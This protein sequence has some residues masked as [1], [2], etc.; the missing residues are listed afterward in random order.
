MVSI[1]MKEHQRHL[2]TFPVC[3]PSVVKQVDPRV[4]SSFETDDKNLEINAVGVVEFCG[5]R[6]LL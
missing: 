2:P 1:P 4:A 3:G 5:E 6:E